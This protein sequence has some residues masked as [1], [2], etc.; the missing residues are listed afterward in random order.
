MKILVKKM[1]KQDMMRFMVHA[2]GP[3]VGVSVLSLTQ[4]HKSVTLQAG[5]A[6]PMGSNISSPIN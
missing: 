3:D 6:E 2:L 1:K 4:C 5:K